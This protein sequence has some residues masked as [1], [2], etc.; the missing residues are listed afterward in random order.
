MIEF[1]KVIEEV[2]LLDLEGKIYLKDLLDRLL[3]EE[4]RKRIRK[5]AKESLR[6]YEEGRMKFGTLKDLKYEFGD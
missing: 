3:I 2:K 4:K 1:H 5:N 6:E